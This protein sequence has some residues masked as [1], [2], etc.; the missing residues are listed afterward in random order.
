MSIDRGVDQEDVIQ[1]HNG[2]YSALKKKE[3]MPFAATWMD[4][5]VIMRRQVIQTKTNIIREHEY[6]ESNKK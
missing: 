6:V 2:I 1:R 4:L 5:E 3:S